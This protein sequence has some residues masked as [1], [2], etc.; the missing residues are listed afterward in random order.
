MGTGRSFDRA[1]LIGSAVQVQTLTP[2]MGVFIDCKSIYGPGA[3]AAESKQE[4]ANA[5][6]AGCVRS[7]WMGVGGSKPMKIRKTAG[8]SFD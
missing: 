6:D 1:G 5:P 8:K 2:S 4:Q 7:N 3:S